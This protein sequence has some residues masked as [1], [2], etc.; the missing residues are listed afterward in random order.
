VLGT[1]IGR[2]AVAQNHAAVR[3][4]L[5]AVDRVRSDGERRYLLVS[6]LNEGALSE[7]ALVE[8]LRLTGDIDS[9]GE[10]RYILSVAVAQQRLGARAQTQYL[11]VARGIDSEGERAYALSMLMREGDGESRPAA[12]ARADDTRTRPAQPT[13]TTRAGASHTR[14]EAGRENVWN[15]THEVVGT[16]DGLPCR[17]LIEARDVLYGREAW[18]VTGIRPGGVLR[19]EQ[20]LGSVRRQVVIRPGANGQLVRTYRVNGQ[21]RPFDAEAER[22]MKQTIREQTEI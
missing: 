8:M 1:A 18:N 4:Y 14:T 6:L 21:E 17:I 15:G 12:G 13:S 5:D 10:K 2:H 3:A 9:D 11:Q 22:W 7:A 19:V 20:D 16:R